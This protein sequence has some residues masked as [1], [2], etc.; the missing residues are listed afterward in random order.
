MEGTG[1]ALTPER[2]RQM[3]ERIKGHF[4]I[5]SN[6]DF[7][8]RLGISPQNINSWFARGAFNELLLATTFPELSGDWLLT[9]EEPMLKADRSAVPQGGMNDLH[10]A[11]A[12]I[13][14]EQKLTARAQSQADKL[15][16][17]LQSLSAT[18]KKLGTQADEK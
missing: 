9:G 6:A 10:R 15:I 17:I 11:L 18:L 1:K 16:I 12:A 7:A 3:L 14:E 2:R 13:A 8:R 4:G 5:D